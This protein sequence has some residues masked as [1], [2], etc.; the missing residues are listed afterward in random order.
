MTNEEEQITNSIVKP[1][2]LVGIIEIVVAYFLM[3]LELGVMK[4]INKFISLKED[5]FITILYIS[6]FIIGLVST[7]F[8]V[9]ILLKQVHKSSSLKLTV[10]MFII[11]ILIFI[12][13]II[14]GYQ[15]VNQTVELLKEEEALESVFYDEYAIKALVLGFDYEEWK[16]DYIKVLN[17]SKSVW[18]KYAF[19][20]SS[21]Y[22][23]SGFLGYIMARIVLR[24][25][26]GRKLFKKGKSNK[27][28]C[29]MEE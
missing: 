4:T 14:S 20:T 10:G 16:I 26:M 21:I 7:F 23:I 13:M 17:E 8:I 24:K 15:Y 3:M 27:I 28:T 9:K 25:V 11:Q 29:F 6:S 19:I 12:V 22:S 2:F 5:I 18:R 1:I